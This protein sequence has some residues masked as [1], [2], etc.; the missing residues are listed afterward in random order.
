MTVDKLC[1]F[2]HVTNCDKFEIYNSANKIYQMTTNATANSVEVE[3]DE[4]EKKDTKTMPNKWLSH[5][6]I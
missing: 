6:L 2:L 3:K 1:N 5:V 4:E